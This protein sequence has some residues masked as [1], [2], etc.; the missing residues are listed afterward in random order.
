MNPAARRQRLHRLARLLD[1]AVHLPGS[2][3]IGIGL[4]GLLGL[5]PGLGDIL[6]LALSSY[7]IVEGARLGASPSVLSR[8]LGNVALD[9]T[10]GL[11]PVAGDIFDIAWQANQRNVAL[12]DG[13]LDN[14]ARERRNARLGLFLVALALFGLLG[15]VL[16]AA[17]ALIKA[18]LGLFR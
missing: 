10:I 9:A 5:I 8:M 3:R 16:F 15:L 2:Q 6:G 13:Y 4:D 1:N 17:L 12:L 14:P 18:L 7:I 11:V